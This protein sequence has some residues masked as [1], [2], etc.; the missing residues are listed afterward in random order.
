VND[1]FERQAALDVLSQAHVGYVAVVTPAG[2]FFVTIPES[3]E[4]AQT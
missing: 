1:G 2:P 3:V 4:S